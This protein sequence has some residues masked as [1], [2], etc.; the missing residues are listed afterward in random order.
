[1]TDAGS[2]PGES[3]ER[4]RTGRLWLAMPFVV[5][6]TAD[7]ALTLSGQP[8]EYWAD[9]HAGA[10]EINPVGHLLLAFGPWA[11]AGAVAVWLVAVSAAVLSWRN[12]VVEWVVMAFTVG[13]G[14]G[15]ACWLARHGGWWFAAG[16]GY[17]AVAAVFARWCWGRSRELRDKG[18]L[19]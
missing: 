4:H 19:A 5:L 10:N 12:R 17:L 9:D 15:G 13:H 16:C 7:V 2:P 3:T 11:F 18:N 8:P 1:V 6:Y 14:I